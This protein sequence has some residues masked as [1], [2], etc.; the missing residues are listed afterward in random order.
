M[1]KLARLALLCSV[2]CFAAAQG[3][4][5]KGAA[6]R[7]PYLISVDVS[8]V[9][10]QATVRDHSGHTVMELKRD[11]FTVF[12]DGKPQTIRLFRHEDT[13][14]TI[15]LVIDHSSSMSEKLADVTGAAQ[16]F[17][18]SSNPDD[19]MFVVNFNERVSQGLPKGTEFSGNA[20]LLGKAIG[21]APALGTTA[22]Y[23]AIVESLRRLQRSTH[24]KKALIVISDGGDNA[25]K[26]TLQNVLQLTGQSNT[27]IYTI[28]IFQAD[29]PDKNPGVLRRLAQESGGEA[30]FPGQ[31]AETV[32]ICQRIARDIRD[33]YTIG[34]SSSDVFPDGAYHKIKLNAREQ[35]SG[36]LF[37]RTRAGY[38]NSTLDKGLDSQ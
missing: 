5:A 11:D 38:K 9:V 37:V 20:E 8:L 24:D 30:F 25:S 21:D 13:P 6:D 4:P 1:K 16:A 12:E 28:G 15:G 32:T 33:Q 31:L 17:V 36:K 23:D 35:G 2:A 27:I 18:T 34:Y 7:G 26:A 22:L 10:L 19:R 14:V 29:D 3:P